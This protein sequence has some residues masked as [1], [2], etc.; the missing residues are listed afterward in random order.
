MA[1][2][3]SGEGSGGLHCCPP[4]DPPLLPYVNAHDGEFKG[5]RIRPD[6]RVQAILFLGF[7]V[8][9]IR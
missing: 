7:L 9:L 6:F 8:L 2:K 5:V 4:L 3:W 1:Q